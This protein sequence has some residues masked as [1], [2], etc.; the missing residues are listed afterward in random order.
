MII[1]FE[2]FSEPNNWY[3]EGEPKL[4]DYVILNINWYNNNKKLEYYLNNT[5]GQISKIKKNY[6]DINSNEYQ[7]LYE[8]IPEEFTSVLQHNRL[9]YVFIKQIKYF[10]NNKEDLE[11]ILNSKKYNL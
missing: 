3:K 1:K 8:N 5:I 7:I 2:K 6:A 11:V 4:H 10:S 9:S